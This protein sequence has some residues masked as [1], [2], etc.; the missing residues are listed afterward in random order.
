[1]LKIR[2]RVIEVASPHQQ[3]ATFFSLVPSQLSQFFVFF[4][5]KRNS[6]NSK[7]EAPSIKRNYI[8]NPTMQFM[9]PWERTSV[10]AA[11]ENEKHDTIYS[12]ATVSAESLYDSELCDIEAMPAIFL[13]PRRHRAK[14]ISP[15]PFFLGGGDHATWC[16]PSRVLMAADSPSKDEIGTNRHN[17]ISS[18]DNFE[19]SIAAAT[20]LD[21]SFDSTHGVELL[22]R[23]KSERPGFI[24]ATAFDVWNGVGL[25]IRCIRDNLIVSGIH[26]DGVFSSKIMVLL[27]FES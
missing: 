20:P 5:S 22:C 11:D 15:M 13:S 12:P 1:M 6:Q 9:F 16:S 24:S 25:T 14:C 18:A 8:L 17:N 21:L 3:T 2:V 27:L 7:A 10:A 4:S 19:A 26:D 23:G